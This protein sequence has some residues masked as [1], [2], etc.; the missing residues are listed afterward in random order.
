MRALGRAA[1]ARKIRSRDHENKVRVPMRVDL[2][3]VFASGCRRC[4]NVEA[5]AMRPKLGNAVEFPG[6]EESAH[7]WNLV[8]R[9]AADH[10]PPPRSG[11]AV[12]A[13]A[14]LEAQP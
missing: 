7:C 6:P 1:C 2:N 13:R 8:R 10:A 4:A 12:P 9:C 11:T 5:G 3:V 14:S